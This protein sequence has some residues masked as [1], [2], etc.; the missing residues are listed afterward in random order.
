MRI[1]QQEQQP[2]VKRDEQAATGQRQ[3]NKCLL[4]LY[5]SNGFGIRFNLGGVFFC[6]LRLFLFFLSMFAKIFSLLRRPDLLLLSHSFAVARL[7]CMCARVSFF[8]FRWFYRLHLHPNF[9]S[10]CPRILLLRL[11][12]L[13]SCFLGCWDW[14]SSSTPTKIRWRRQRRKRSTKNALLMKGKRK[15]IYKWK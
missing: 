11:C 14:I 3:E 10:Y 9:S 2:M 4:Y 6:S 5:R 12:D 7:L 1:R 8:P 15:Q 13:N